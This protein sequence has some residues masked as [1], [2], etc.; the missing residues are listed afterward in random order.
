MRSNDKDRDFAEPQIFE[1][2]SDQTEEYFQV[3]ILVPDLDVLY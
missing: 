2:D 1:A 3:I